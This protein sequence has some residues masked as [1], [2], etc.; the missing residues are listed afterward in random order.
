MLYDEVGPA[1]GIAPDAHIVCRSPYR[2]C[3]RFERAGLTHLRADALSGSSTVYG[4]RSLGM[5]RT[6]TYRPF[7]DFDTEQVADVVLEAWT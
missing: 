3:Y 7:T 6:S 1:G 2:A 5:Q 4:E